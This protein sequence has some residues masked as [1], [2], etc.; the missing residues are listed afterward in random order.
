MK[1]RVHLPPPLKRRSR[2]KPG[3]GWRLVNA[4]RTGSVK[5]VLLAT[6]ASSGERYAIFR[7]KE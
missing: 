5:G 6:Y 1:K 2:L 4:A 7:L 3:K